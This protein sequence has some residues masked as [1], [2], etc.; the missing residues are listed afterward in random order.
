MGLAHNLL[1]G[2]CRDWQLVLSGTVCGCVRPGRFKRKAERTQHSEQA[3]SLVRDLPGLSEPAEAVTPVFE[4]CNVVAAATMSSEKDKKRGRQIQR[5]F[6]ICFMGARH[7]LQTTKEQ[8]SPTG[9]FC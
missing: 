7:P 6:F 9:P 1:S 3:S 8:A 4:T 2:T 5:F